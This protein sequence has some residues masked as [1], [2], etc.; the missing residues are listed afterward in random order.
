M[1]DNQVCLV[2]LQRLINLQQLGVRFTW[3]FPTPNLK[4]A[5][6][7]LS[8]HPSKHMKHPNMISALRLG[9]TRLDS[10][11]PANIHHLSPTTVKEATTQNPESGLLRWIPELPRSHLLSARDL[12]LGHSL[13]ETLLDEVHLVLMSTDGKLRAVI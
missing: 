4:H 3:L 9:C 6:L 8:D 1:P 2:L 5:C 10:E 12:V 13:L 7:L 11:A